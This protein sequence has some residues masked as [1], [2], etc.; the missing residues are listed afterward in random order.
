[1][2]SAKDLHVAPIS[3]QDARRFV[4][5]HHYSGKVDPRSQ[6]HLGAFLDG[7]LVG[8]A[9]FGP[10]IARHK[11][12]GL[13][14]GTPWNSM[15]ELNR[16]VLI[17]DT[18]RNSE[19][20]FLAMSIRLIKIHAPH[21]QWVLSY[22]DGTQCGDGTIYRA[23]GFVLTAI[24]KNM[25]M[26]RMPDGEVQAKIVF[27]PGFSVRRGGVDNGVKARYGKTGGGKTG[28]FLKEIGAERLAGFMLRYIYF[29]D[30]TA[31]ARLTVP[32]VPFSD[33][34]RLGAGM[35]LGQPRAGSIAVD[36]SPDQ[37]EEG[38]ASP[39]PAL[40]TEARKA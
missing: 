9:Q 29:I 28:S 12:I 23:S 35:Y 38:G 40:H 24:K 15:F 1:M 27:E 33:I 32:E 10:P 21:I 39:T 2:A 7:R 13:V 17:D 14:R 11:V 36:A 3:V 4:R 6:L 5:E 31:R 37:G 16:L 26:Y 22:A 8:V 20:R 18:P 34:E 19:S 25:S 30:P